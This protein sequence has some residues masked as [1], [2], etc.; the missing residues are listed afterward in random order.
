MYDAIIIGCGPAGIT[1]SIYLLRAN[2]K[3]LILEKEGIGGATASSPLVENYPGYKSISGSELTSNMF[4]QAD[5]LGVDIE[6]ETVT[7][8]EDI[9]SIKKVI[10]EDNIYETK[11]IIIA[12][13]SRYR[14]L[15]L[16]RES[17]LI[18]KGIHFC[19][20]CDGMFY[21]DKVVAIVGGGNSSCINAISLAKFAK[22]VYIIQNINH[23]TGEAALQQDIELSNNIEIL[24]NSVVIEYLGEDHITGILI[25][26][27]NKEEKLNIDGVFLSIGLIPQNE[28]AKDILDIDSKGYIVSKDCKTN[29]NGIYVAGDS[30]TK[31]FRQVTLA[32]GDGTASALLA[33]NYLN[34]L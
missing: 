12:S 21:K 16:P 23:L 28:F 10:T 29:V 34:S 15:G 31:E 33:I 22:K 8:I 32:V 2:K 25:K 7:K 20:A 6:M 5:N 13:G 9:G 4:D 11:T 26:K 14:T 27:D 3:V 17:E 24:Y 18:G 1:A 30:R 19:V